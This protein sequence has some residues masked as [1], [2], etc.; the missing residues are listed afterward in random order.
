LSS[1]EDSSPEEQDEVEDGEESPSPD[2]E[3]AFENSRSKG[4]N[5]IDD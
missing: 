5:V 2:R 4:K 3:A 1:R